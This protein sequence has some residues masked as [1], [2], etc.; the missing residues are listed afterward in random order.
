M[1]G[2]SECRIIHIATGM[3]I[4]EGD[5][6]VNLVYNTHTKFNFCVFGEFDLANTGGPTAGDVDVIRRLITQWGGGLMDHV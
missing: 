2:T 6:I 4:V 1:P 3:T 5:P